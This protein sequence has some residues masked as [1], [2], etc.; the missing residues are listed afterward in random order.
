MD[1]DQLIKAKA[2]EIAAKLIGPSFPVLFQNKEGKLKIHAGFERTVKGV[3]RY[4]R[5][6]Q[7]ETFEMDQEE[8][9]EVI[10]RF[11]ESKT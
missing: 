2:L 3:E 8:L 11:A 9:E 6:E 5:G 7:P 10:R 1:Q 4:L